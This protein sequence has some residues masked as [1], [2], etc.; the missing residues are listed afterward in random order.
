MKNSIFLRMSMISWLVLLVAGNS[1]AD[2]FR[3]L[4]T[5]SKP[6]PLERS[7]G[8]FVELEDGAGWL[9]LLRGG[10]PA[11]L[12]A[13]PVSDVWVFDGSD[14]RSINVA[15]PAVYGHT[16]VAAGE[17]RAFGFGGVDIN[18][19][20]IR[21]DTVLSYRV[22]RGSA[23]PEVTIDQI[24][25]SGANPGTCSEAPV[26]RLE[27]RNSMLL[28]GGMCSYFPG[29]SSEVWEYRVG[30]NS[31]HQRAD[32][33]RALAD[34]TAVVANGQVWVFGGRGTDGRS[35]EVY[36][37]DPQS[38]SWSE[39]F[40][41][42]GRPEP[43]SDHRAV[44][45]GESMLVFGGIRDNFW[46][47][48]ISEVWE[49]DLTALQWTRKSDLPHGLAEMAV[50]VLPLEFAGGSG[51][52][53]LLV[54]GVIDAWSFPLV[55]SDETWV[56][57][58]DIVGPDELIAVPAV[59][60]LRGRGALFTSTAYLMNIGDV[61]LDLELTFTPRMDMGGAQ[62]TAQLAIAPGILKT[63]DDPLTTLFGFGENDGAVG[64]LLIEVSDG[65]AND[66]LTQTFVT[67]EL[68]SGEEYG[69]YFPAIRSGRALAASEVGYL[70]TTEDPSSYRVNVGLMALTDDTEISVA[71]VTRIGERMTSAVGFNLD[72][73]ENVQINDIHKSFSIGSVAD[74]MIEVAI[75]SGKAIAYAT[76][77]D[78]NGSYAGTSD[79]TTIQP[80]VFGSQQVTLLEIGSVQGLDEF[81]GSAT[82]VNLSDRAA[83][84]RADFFERGSQGVSNSRILTIDPGD[85]VGYRDFVG[86][87]FGV[88]GT[89]G[90]V[91][92]ESLN[93]ARISATGR[94]FA[95][96]R[97]EYSDEIFG[98]AGTQLPGLTEA[99][100]L[101]TGQTWHVIGLRQMMAGDERER[102]HL[103]VF[104]PG[105]QSVR[106]T[107]ILFDGDNGSIEGSRYWI[108]ESHESIHINNVMK[109]INSS[110]D[111]GE[112]RIEI[113]VDRPV[114]LQ[115]Y[116][117]N[118]WGD[119]VTLRPEGR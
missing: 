58:S 2:S 68:D 21:L 26:V 100:L 92:L 96:L 18:D 30:D 37:Y 81:S 25:V 93:G 75:A 109:K 85:A 65:F 74:V 20:L 7:G 33:P 111:G 116:R 4:E 108:I 60:R 52:Q 115:A 110:V 44:A 97:D 12:N 61:E 114:Y 32:L 67:A 89:V 90:S 6:I 76:V 103:A 49:L 88:F 69:T 87:I 39:V 77:V 91:V 36:R 47:E 62:V 31:W 38:D 70:T 98:T 35:N 11:V 46:P 79:P 104:N 54:D 23:G 50:G 15:A 14:W 1:A 51:E 106:L 64:S 95:S 107:V 112:K 72:G 94:E 113:S 84:V 55:L 53:V 59:A 34:H 42:G 19:E 40:A 101:T 45:I 56:Y 27:N 29:W 118:T 105:S 9:F 80:I 82:I 5:Q 13:K 3:L 86:D 48:T 57:T 78:G 117:V 24:A 119:S 63:I 71:P 99:E 73:G 10:L 17:G 66:L 102:S 22:R 8:A 83:E 41:N 43:L 28:V 16:L